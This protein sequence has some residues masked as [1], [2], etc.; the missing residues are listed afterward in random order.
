METITLHSVGGIS[1]DPNG[2]Q[3]IQYELDSS[4][5]ITDVCDICDESIES[6]WLCLDGGEVVCDE[7]IILQGGKG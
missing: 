1:R 4:E 5:E 6:G 3:W 7:H 2:N